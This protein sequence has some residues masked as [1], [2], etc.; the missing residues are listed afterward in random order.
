MKKKSKKNKK[1]Y[2]I[3]GISIF[4]LAIFAII[5]VVLMKDHAKAEEPEREQKL[6]LYEYYQLKEQNIYLYN[7]SEIDLNIDG[8]NMTLKEYIADNKNMDN[9]FA[10][11]EKYLNITKTLKDGGTIIY[12]TKKNNKVFA[13]D[14]TIIRCHTEDGNKDVYFGNDY[15]TLAAFQSG[16]CGKN[17]FTDKNFTRVYTIEKIKELEKDNDNYLLELTIKDQENNKKTTITRKM[18]KESRD[19]LK[20]NREYVFYFENKYTELIKEDI[21]DI[22]NKCTLTGVV[23]NTK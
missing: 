5:V 20:E 23:P 11:L 7:V 12:E 2:L 3:M 9:V 16:A 1:K 22:F 13:N 6:D 15:S 4:I 18:Q 10:K 17:F 19:I 21:E 8:K 14:L